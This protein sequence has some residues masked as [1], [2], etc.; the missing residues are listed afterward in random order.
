[1]IKIQKN[2]K[3]VKNTKNTK[4]QKKLSGLRFYYK[5]QNRVKQQKYKQKKT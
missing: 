2:T 5:K 4:V 3:N 1:M